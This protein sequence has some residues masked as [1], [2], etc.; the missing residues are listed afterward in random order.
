LL[1]W[2]KRKTFGDGNNAGD[3]LAL[4]NVPEGLLGTPPPEHAHRSAIDDVSTRSSR[5]SFLLNQ[6]LP[7][8]E[9][10]GQYASH[11]PPDYQKRPIPNPNCPL[12]RMKRVIGTGTLADPSRAQSLEAPPDTVEDAALEQG[13]AR[14]ERWA[15]DGVYARYHSLLYSVAF[16]VLRNADDAQDCLHDALIRV[17]TKR[18]TYDVARG[19][20]RSFLVVCVRNQAISQQRTATR[21]AKL[22]AKVSNESIG[23]HELRI[24]DFVENRR[25]YAAFMSLPLEQRTPLALSYFLG[26]THVEIARELALPLG[27]TKSRISLGLRR[28][29]KALKTKVP[30]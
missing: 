13:F 17:W 20:L 5:M 22:S 1:G 19:T 30:S 16:N 7:N 8:P 11:G 26:K 6:L 3:A 27:T 10:Y 21:L 24:D 18:V 23:P 28:L 15:L 12:E 2:L 25:L 9:K 29:G 14:R 4:E